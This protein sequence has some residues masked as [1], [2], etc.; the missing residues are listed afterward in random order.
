MATLSF[1]VAI[2]AI[3]LF[4]LT[5][6]DSL[7]NAATFRKLT[8]RNIHV[9]SLNVTA[10][11]SVQ[12]NS[13]VNLGTGGAPLGSPS[14]VDLCQIALQYTHPG[15][16]DTVNTYIG[17]PLNSSEW[18]SRF[19]MDG[20][21]GWI[22]GG[23][24]EIL[25]PVAAGYATSST[26]GGHDLTKATIQWGLVSEGNV[27]WPALNDFASVALNE[28]ATLGKMAAKLY[29]DSDP[30]YSYWN[31]CSTGGRQ[32][33]M[34][35]QRYPQQFDGIVA[36]CPAINWQRF[37]V[38][39]LWP[40]VMAQI[41]DAIPPPCV[42]QAFQHAAIIACDDYDGVRDNIISDPARCDFDAKSLI[43]QTV[44]CTDPL[45]QIVVTED[46]AKL[47]ND[48]WKGPI[49]EDGKFEWYGLHHDSNMTYL[50][51]T[52][53]TSVDK[54]TLT[55]FSIAFDWVG[56]FLAKNSSFT[57]EGL[58]RK[59]YDRYFRQSVDE[60]SSVI[61]TDNPDLTEFKALGGKM[62]TWHGMQ[63]PLI[64]PNGTVDY[65][66]RVL[67]QDADAGNYCRFFLAPGVGHCG[68]G[69]GFDPSS[70][71]FNAVRAWVENG[72]FPETLTGIGA[73]VGSD[74][75]NSTRSAQ[76]C[77][78]PKVL[79]YIGP[80]ANSESSFICK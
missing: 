22:A 71:V 62:I 48:I 43:G 21:G 28:A 72:T 68:Y 15:Q 67:R 6:A 34:M 5:S 39:E 52:S 19:L 59:E 38:S 29:F 53:C 2:L 64:P 37:I 10:L 31:R 66:K 11:R 9:L 41:L 44:H 78:Y 80:D 73:A 57:L 13:S 14:T 65:Y 40:A 33:H 63:D 25:A 24:A 77:G 30:K 42:L 50:L 7:C 20:G 26:D 45:G 69:Y 54:C 23:E 61:G 4:S 76:L 46:L 16:H 70:T 58:T 8:L 47:V 3:S 1:I 56:V 74:A 35:A 36:G 55:P 27:N 75:V 32:G 49:S 60:F 17:L 51:N 79:T 18:N 12:F